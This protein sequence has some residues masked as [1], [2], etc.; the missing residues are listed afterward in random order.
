MTLDESD[1]TNGTLGNHLLSSYPTRPQTIRTERLTTDFHIPEP[2]ETGA[3]GVNRHTS[4]TTPH[5]LGAFPRLYSTTPKKK[6]YVLFDRTL[7]SKAPFCSHA[8]SGT[9]TRTESST[10][11]L[12]GIKQRLLLAPL[13]EHDVVRVVEPDPDRHHAPSG[14]RLASYQIYSP[15]RLL[16]VGCWCRLW[17]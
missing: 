14:I 17:G 6:H 7:A 15:E 10:A 12:P 3:L 16:R 11:N 8:C 2:V 4:T 5:P 1:A 13:S 9:S